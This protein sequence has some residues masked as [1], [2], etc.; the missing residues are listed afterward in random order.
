MSE[1]GGWGESGTGGLGA[2]K[3]GVRRGIGGYGDNKGLWL[4]FKFQNLEFELVLGLAPLRLTKNSKRGVIQFY[5]FVSYI[6][7]FNIVLLNNKQSFFD[8]VLQFK[9]TIAITKI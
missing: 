6:N 2:K 7:T 3:E 1:T 9:K 8:S 5:S 4:L